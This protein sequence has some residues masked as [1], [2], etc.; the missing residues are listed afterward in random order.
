M[1]NMIYIVEIQADCIPC[2]IKIVGFSH[3][4]KLLEVK[5]YLLTASSKRDFINYHSDYK[6]RI[7]EEEFIE[8]CNFLRPIKHAGKVRLL[9]EFNQ[10]AEHKR[11]KIIK[12]IKTNFRVNKTPDEKGYIYSCKIERI[13]T[14]YCKNVN[15]RILR[16]EEDIRR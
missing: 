16:K 7:P 12:N 11:K 4:R 14:S 2:F 5:K 10:L 15:R 13:L 9:S 8:L 6:P 1:K 3:P